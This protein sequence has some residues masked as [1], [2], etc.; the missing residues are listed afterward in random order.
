MTEQTEVLIGSDFGA[1]LTAGAQSKKIIAIEA[2]RTA[3]RR[4]QIPATG[5]N[6]RLV[7][8]CDPGG[9]WPERRRGWTIPELAKSIREDHTVGVAAF[10]FPFSI[11]L[12]LLQSAGFADRVG[13]PVFGNRTAWMHFVA[14]HM[15]LAFSSENAGAKFRIDPVLYGWKDKGYWTKRAT[16]IATSAQ[17]PLKHMYQNLFNM[18]LA[19]SMFLECLRDGGM[20]VLLRPEERG[21]PCDRSVIET[22]P[23]AVAAAVGFKGNYKQEPR[24]CLTAAEEYL[25][26]QGI[27][28]DFDRDVRNFCL[29]YRTPPNDPDGADAFLCLVAAICGREGFAKWHTGDGSP[30][31]L[32]E[33]GCIV[34]PMGPSDFATKYLAQFPPDT[35]I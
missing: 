3:D 10:D 29:D 26:T 18:T 27:A 15:D 7:R 13:V 9:G 20:Q 11:P 35:T 17:A 1:P 19:G 2:S 32:A 34:T 14:L 28:L 22:Y 30:Q 24:R 12:K 33:E 23:G 31:Q 21:M 6:E 4:Y 25:H 16:D 5:R 8:K